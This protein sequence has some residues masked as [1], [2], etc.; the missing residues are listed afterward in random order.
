[1]E[2]SATENTKA[3]QVGWKKL[4]L[5]QISSLDNICMPC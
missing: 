4:R 3:Y 5:Q 1:M 2:I